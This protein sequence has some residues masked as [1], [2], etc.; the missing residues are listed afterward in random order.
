MEINSQLIVIYYRFA[1]LRKNKTDL[2]FKTTAGSTNHTNTTDIVNEIDEYNGNDEAIANIIL[3]SRLLSDDIITKRYIATKPTNTT[4]ATN[5]PTTTISTSTAATTPITAT[6]TTATIKT[7]SDLVMFDIRVLS[8]IYFVDC[9]QPLPITTKQE[10]A[11]NGRMP[12][13]RGSTQPSIS[14][15]VKTMTN[16]ITPMLSPFNETIVQS[17]S[18]SD[19]LKMAIVI[20]LIKVNQMVLQQHHQVNNNDEEND[21]MVITSTITS[22]NKKDVKQST[23]RSNNN[24]NNLKKEANIGVELNIKKEESKKDLKIT[25]KLPD[26]QKAKNQSTP[27]TTATAP[28]ASTS[29]STTLATTNTNTSNIIIPPPPLPDSKKR[30]QV[31]SNS[32]STSTN[33]NNTNA[34]DKNDKD[35]CSDSPRRNSIDS[36]NKD[37]DKD[38]EKSGKNIKKDDKRNSSSTALADVNGGGSGR[39]D[40]RFNIDPTNSHQFIESLYY[41]KTIPPCSNLLSANFFSGTDGG[42]EMQSSITPAVQRRYDFSNQTLVPFTG[43]T[44]F[45]R[46]SVSSTCQNATSN[47]KIRYIA[48]LGPGVCFPSEQNY[49]YYSNFTYNQDTNQ[50]SYRVGQECGIKTQVKNISAPIACN[51]TENSDNYVNSMTLTSPMSFQLSSPI[52]TSPYKIVIPPINQSWPVSDIQPSYNINYKQKVQWGSLINTIEQSITCPSSGCSLPITTS[53]IFGEY[54]TSSLTNLPS[55]VSL[56]ITPNYF[57]GTNTQLLNSTFFNVSISIPKVKTVTVIATEYTSITLRID[58]DNTSLGNLAK[59]IVKANDKCITNQNCIN[60]PECTIDGIS[61]NTNLQIVIQAVTYGY[62]GEAYTLNTS[63]KSLPI[64]TTTSVP[65]T[66]TTSSPTTTS[67]SCPPIN[68]STRLV[69]SSISIILFST[70]SIIRMYLK[71]NNLEIV[72]YLH[73]NRS[74][75][76]SSKAMENAIDAGNIEIVSW[77]YNNRTEDFNQQTMDKLFVVISQCQNGYI[78]I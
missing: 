57:V 56:T 40:Y 78:Q 23:N 74:E 11:T 12:R 31:E 49:N 66:T 14:T 22:S 69:Q 50:I 34:Q 42:C 77:L 47:D 8:Y 36:S 5:E 73:S 17:T 72:K 41:E 58:L 75:G 61:P 52:S 54:C 60:W 55:N 4:N 35:K 38:K 65:S 24:N 68:D 37:N 62:A 9:K 27:T 25:I 43:Y 18:I 6:T 30:K 33:N 71:K 53:P 39:G 59:Y 63:T 48:K 3:S 1:D 64:S 44:Y 46:F 2:W 29:A 7:N 21:D 32:S 20:V 28:A 13:K 15:I 51:I 10:G 16:P 45:E 70:I 67:S 19:L 26:K 76:C